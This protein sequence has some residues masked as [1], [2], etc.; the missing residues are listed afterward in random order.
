MF[1]RGE[2]KTITVNSQSSPVKIAARTFSRQEGSQ[3][4]RGRLLTTRPLGPDLKSMLEI[5]EMKND[6][7]RLKVCSV[8][9]YKNSQ[10]EKGVI[11]IGFVA[12]STLFY[13]T[14]FTS[15]SVHSVGC[16]RVLRFCK[17]ICHVPHI[18]PIKSRREVDSG[19]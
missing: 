11:S 4:K 15:N 10:P 8:A 6:S 18:M 9:L 2:N 17:R 14:G 7:Y 1:V 5:F 13:F 16:F 19:G 12:Y 3:L